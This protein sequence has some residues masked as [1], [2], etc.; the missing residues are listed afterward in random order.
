[1]SPDDLVLNDLTEKGYT[2]SSYETTTDNGK[3]TFLLT[4]SSDFD[5]AD[6][7]KTFRRNGLNVDDF[8]VQ[9][10]GNGIYKNYEIEVTVFT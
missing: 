3:R 5:A 10:E 8:S 6:L 4:S 2:I 7:L 9:E 1:M